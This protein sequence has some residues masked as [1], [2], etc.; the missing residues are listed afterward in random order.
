MQ[1]TVELLNHNNCFMSSSLYCTVPVIAVNT[2]QVHEISIH[3]KLRVK[4]YKTGQLFDIYS[5]ILS[6]LMLV[7]LE[8]L[9]HDRS[10]SE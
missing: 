9:L 7:M 2:G 3:D 6:W 5:V 8:Y 4:A 10:H 1:S